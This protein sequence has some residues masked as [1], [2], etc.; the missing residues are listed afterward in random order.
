MKAKQSPAVKHLKLSPITQVYPTKLKRNNLNSFFKEESPEFFSKLKDDV[1]ARGI[2]VPIIAKKDG[3]ILAGHNRW[4]VSKLLSLPTV[5]VQYLNQ[6][7]SLDEERKFVIGDNVLRRQLKSEDRLNLY[8]LIYPD[9]DAELG[10]IGRGNNKSGNIRPKIIAN[11]LGLP[12]SSVN[13]D[14]SLARANAEIARRSITNGDKVNSQF[15]D[16]FKRNLT[17]LLKSCKYENKQTQDSCADILP[18]YVEAF[19]NLEK[20]SLATLIDFGDNVRLKATRKKEKDQK[21]KN[22]QALVANNNSAT[23]HKEKQK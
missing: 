15:L 17:T 16:N 14:I 3:T 22:T 9:F 7:L 2:L 13:R 20:L 19:N 8:R 12:I 5:P 1:R 10:S 23:A 18:I 4:Y 6:V 21:L 11:D